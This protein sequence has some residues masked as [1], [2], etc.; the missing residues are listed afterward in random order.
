MQDSLTSIKKGINLYRVCYTIRENGEICRPNGFHNFDAAQ[1]IIAD[2]NA[3]YGELCKYF[4]EPVNLKC[5]SEETIVSLVHQE[6][7]SLNEALPY[8]PSNSPH[9]SN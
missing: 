5:L 1:K 4:L 7:L 6:K 2:F 8:L 9:I 3:R